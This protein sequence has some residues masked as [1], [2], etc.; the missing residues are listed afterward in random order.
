L[1]CESTFNQWDDYAAKFFLQD[2]PKTPIRQYDG[3]LLFAVQSLGLIDP[4]AGVLGRRLVPVFDYTKL[5]LFLLSVLWR[6]ALCFHDYFR[7]VTLG[8]HI[9]AIRAMV[10]KGNAGDP[11]SYACYLNTFDDSEAKQVAFCPHRLKFCGVNGYRIFMAGCSVFI[12]VDSRP[13]PAQ[14]NKVVLKPNS[15]LRVIHQKWANSLEHRKVLEIAANATVHR[16]K[17]RR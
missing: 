15:P 8:V 7:N 12:K 11:D 16:P 2:L 5:K 6:A 17:V 13:L 9:G 4:D 10:L 14:Y 1:D 3:D